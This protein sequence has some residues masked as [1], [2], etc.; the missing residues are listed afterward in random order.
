MRFSKD[1]T[2]MPTESAVPAPY[3][4]G[5][6]IGTCSWKYDAW[7][8]LVYDPDKRYAPH[9]FLAD[10]ARH[11][12]TVEV[13]QWFWSL[14]PGGVSLPSPATV[15][16]YVESV[17]DDFLFTVKAP[18]AITLTH[19]YAKQA[20]KDKAFANREN[21]N[22]LD[23][24]ILSRFLELLDPMQEKLGPIMFQFEYLNRNKMPSL[25]VFM[26]RLRQFFDQAPAGYSY[27]IE[28]RNPNYLRKPFFSFLKE[29][30]LSTVLLEGYYMPPIA[31]TAATFDIATGDR[32]VLRLH[33]PDRSKIEQQTKG[34]WN[35]IVAPQDKSLAAAAHIVRKC[36]EIDLST[37]V[38]VNNHYEGCAPLSIQRLLA[39]LE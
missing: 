21:P 19:Y 36:R 3:A 4:P 25:Q 13:D 38:N 33:G 39:R 14:F 24:D 28:I 18:N 2:P 34:V 5:L 30:G 23:A 32:L 6:R 10:Y 29:R 1:M 26:E 9:D 8:G 27:A 16:R 31:E 12:S 37:V 17:P 35:K 11:F 15:S 20:A 22:F 7:K